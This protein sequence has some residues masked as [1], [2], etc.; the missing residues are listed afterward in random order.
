MR[1]VSKAIKSAYY[2]PTIK[3]YNLLLQYLMEISAIYYTHFP[4]KKMKTQVNKL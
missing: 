1:L 4:E 3:L 2:K